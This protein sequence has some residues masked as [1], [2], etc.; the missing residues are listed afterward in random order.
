MEKTKS[1]IL[2]LEKRIL[3]VY[4]ITVSTILILFSSIFFIIFNDIIMGYYCL[5]GSLFPITSLILVYLLS[6]KTINKIIHFHL[7]I[8]PIYLSFPVIYFWSYSIMNLCWYIPIPFIVYI[9]F[10]KNTFIKYMI[11]LII[12]IGITFFIA[13]DFNYYSISSYKM[14]RYTDLLVIGSNILTMCIFLHYKDRLRKIQI[15]YDKKRL[16]IKNRI[17][18][19]ENNISSTISLFT[20]IDALMIEK[21]FFTNPKFSISQLSIEVGANNNYISQSIRYHGYLNFNHYVNHYRINNV[22]KLIKENDMS[23]I[24][25]FYIYS[26]AGFNNQSTFNKVFKD[27][28]GITPSE[29]IDFIQKNKL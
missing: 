12:V 14:L 24:K 22:K 11:Y 9:F 10:K 3:K 1:H 5:I 20:K 25:L 2:N 18:T 28:E 19:N 29:Y 6:I 17:I 7:I 13:N 23:K 8:G 27:F 21:E 16:S 26:K 4:D 15:V